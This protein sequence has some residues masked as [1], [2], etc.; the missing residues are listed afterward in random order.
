MP[1]EDGSQLSG[2]IWNT[3]WCS[4]HQYKRKKHHYNP[5]VPT[6]IASLTLPTIPLKEGKL[7]GK[8]RE[9]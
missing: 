7:Y 4:R 9:K 3:A 2:K 1:V 8:R 6:C 5:T